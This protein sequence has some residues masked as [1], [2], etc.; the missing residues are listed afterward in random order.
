M[1]QKKIKT[2]RYLLEICKNHI[3]QS[4]IVVFTITG[5]VIG[6][7]FSFL[8]E[9]LTSSPK[10]K[11]E[12]YLIGKN[13]VP[14]IKKSK[15]ILNKTIVKKEFQKNLIKSPNLPITIVTKENTI[16]NKGEV[17]KS[18]KNNYKIIRNS[19]K[20]AI[21]SPTSEKK[22][23]ISPSLKYN[24]KSKSKIAI[25]FDDLG[26]DIHR[27]ARAIK[28]KSPLT[29]SFITYAPKLKNQT[30]KARNAGH[31]LWMHMP[32]EPQNQSIDPGPNVL[33]TGLPKEELLAAINWNLKQFNNYVGIN[34]HMGS[35]FTSDLESVRIFMKE[36]KK[37]NLMFLDSRTSNQSVAQRAAIEA[38]VPFIVRNIFIDHL[39]ETSE[40]RK[41]LV[42]IERLAEKNGYAVAIAH[43][44][45]KTL[46]EVEKWLN[47]L[48]EK[49]L[50][51]VPLSKLINRP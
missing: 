7:G 16:N 10:L 29:L 17:K 22:N 31:E 38:K 36:L 48:E 20:V 51:L 12:A 18:V 5:I 1:V 15:I 32:M 28:L 23:I 34:N 14:V 2:T 37:R 47:T 26:I 45:D 40:I 33:L 24:A 27:S 43:P 4:L 44:R 3:L 39:D 19:S 9:T 35:R 8:S 30:N 41:S 11:T 25:V 13:T 49:G 6:Y 46:K 21:K 42:Q 50:Q